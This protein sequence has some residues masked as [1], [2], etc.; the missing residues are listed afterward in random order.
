MEGIVLI[1]IVLSNKY[2]T[3]LVRLQTEALTEKKQKN[4]NIAC[5]INFNYYLCIANDINNKI[6]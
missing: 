3:F 6:K 1:V 5:D 2:T 4:K